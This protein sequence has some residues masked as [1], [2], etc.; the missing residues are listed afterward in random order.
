VN[1]IIY[2]SLGSMKK[3]LLLSTSLTACSFLAFTS[4]IALANPE[5]GVV[6]AGTASIETSVGR[7]DVHQSSDKAVIDWRT[8]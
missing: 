5:G 8:L 7:V 6:S 1:E 4:S 3:L 2:V